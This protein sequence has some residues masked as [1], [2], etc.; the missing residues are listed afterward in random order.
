MKSSIDSCQN[1]NSF[2]SFTFTDKNF[3]DA[4]F[5]SE[6]Q[7]T[8]QLIDLYHKHDDEP[9]FDCEFLQGINPDYCENRINLESEEEENNY[10]YNLWGANI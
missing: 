5:H 3:V 8:S 9:D 6:K 10:N 1:F 4:E 7:S 2:K